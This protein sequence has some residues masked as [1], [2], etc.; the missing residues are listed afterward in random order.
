VFVLSGLG[1]Q[2]ATGLPGAEAIPGNGV[3]VVSPR[4][5]EPLAANNL[6]QVVGTVRRFDQRTIEEEL[7]VDLVG[8]PGTI[9]AQ[10]AGRPVIVATAVAPAS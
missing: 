5:L 9:F 4:P 3:L 2:A 7:G 6:V 1:N 8:V 10:W